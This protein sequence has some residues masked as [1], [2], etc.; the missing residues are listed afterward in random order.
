MK[1]SGESIEREW[2]ESGFLIMHAV[3][4]G[5]RYSLAMDS[6]PKEKAARCKTLAAGPSLG[7]L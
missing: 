6:Y 2:R 3:R 7:C 5:E 4:S 1:A